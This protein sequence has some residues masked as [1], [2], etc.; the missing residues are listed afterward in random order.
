MYGSHAI[1]VTIQI[2]LIELLGVVGGAS[3]AMALFTQETCNSDAYTD[4]PVT[5]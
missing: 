3:A 1:N 2:N 5:E 4:T